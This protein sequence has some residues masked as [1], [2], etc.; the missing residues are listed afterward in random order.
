MMRTEEAVSASF[1]LSNVGRLTRTANMNSATAGERI[2][3]RVLRLVRSRF[4]NIRR[5]NLAMAPPRLLR[6]LQR[7][8]RHT[9]R[10]RAYE[11]TLV[12]TIN[13][14]DESLRAGVVR[15]HDDRLVILAIEL[16]KQKQDLF[17]RFGVQVAR[18]FIRD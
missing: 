6:G 10:R 12:E 1:W 16:C 4:L 2:V 14:V 3:R 13:G 5:V 8:G 18:R 11:Y 17:R 15:D 9:A 7:C